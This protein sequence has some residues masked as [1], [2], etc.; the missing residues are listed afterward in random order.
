MNTHRTPW[1]LDDE[2]LAGYAANLG[3]GLVN[4]LFSAIGAIFSLFTVLL[5][6]ST[7]PSFA[8][9]ERVQT[10]VTRYAQCLQLLLTDPQEHVR[11]CGGGKGPIPPSRDSLSTPVAGAPAPVWHWPNGCAAAVMIRSSSSCP[12]E[13]EG[14]A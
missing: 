12:V 1:H 5:F 6:A 7:G 3:L 8:F 10:Q 13:T 9:N 14:P 4:V 2:D 11:V